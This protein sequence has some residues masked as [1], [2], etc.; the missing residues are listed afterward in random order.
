MVYALRDAFHTGDC[1]LPISG[2]VAGAASV[3]GAARAWQPEAASRS[4]AGDVEAA[5]RGTATNSATQ[6]N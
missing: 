2:L 6:K 4:Q 3:A 5:A 1:K